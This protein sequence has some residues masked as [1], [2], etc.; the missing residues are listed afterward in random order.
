[1]IIN[2]GLDEVVYNA[3]YPLG[4]AALDLLREAGVKFRQVSIDG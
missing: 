2:V 4:G 1:M 3:H